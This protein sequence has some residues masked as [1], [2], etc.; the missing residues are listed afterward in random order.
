MYGTRLTDGIEDLH[1]IINRVRRESLCEIV[2]KHTSG[3]D[4]RG[5]H[6][7]EDDDMIR[8]KEMG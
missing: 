6:F 2:L 7:A 3:E 5:T 1:L 4:S 8:A